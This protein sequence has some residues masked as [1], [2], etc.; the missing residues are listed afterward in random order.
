[1]MKVRELIEK[2]QA[3][4]PELEVVILVESEQ[5]HYSGVDILSLGDYQHGS[6][7][8]GDFTG[9]TW[10]HWDKEQKEWVPNTNVPVNAVLLDYD[11]S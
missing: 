7:D 3:I 10:L 9:A 4:D 8:F 11:L 6:R 1:M 2:L 5:E